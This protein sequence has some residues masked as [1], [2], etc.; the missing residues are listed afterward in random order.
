L[1]LRVP[2]AIIAQ[3]ALVVFAQ[4]VAAMDRLYG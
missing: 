3:L 2:L 4:P 1:M